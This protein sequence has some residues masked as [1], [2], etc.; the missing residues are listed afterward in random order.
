MKQIAQAFQWLLA[1]FGLSAFEVVAIAFLFVLLV[2]V[3]V[4]AQRFGLVELVAHR[5][6]ELR[7]LGEF[8]LENI[9]LIAEGQD[10]NLAPYEKL[11]L[12][13]EE[14]GLSYIDPRMLMVLDKADDYVS[15]RVGFDVSFEHLYAKAET[16]YF[17][18]KKSVPVSVDETAS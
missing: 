2:I 6:K 16:L 11:A 8:L 4:A 1:T 10:I 15:G 14:N 18:Y 13:R 5:E 17:H 12:E 3:S 9:V 7:L